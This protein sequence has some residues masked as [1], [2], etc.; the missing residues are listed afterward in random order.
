MMEEL[1]KKELQA[2]YRPQHTIDKKTAQNIRRYVARVQFHDWWIFNNT[3]P[4][5]TTLNGEWYKNGI[6]FEWDGNGKLTRAE[7]KGV[8]DVISMTFALQLS[9]EQLARQEREQELAEQQRRDEA[10]KEELNRRDRVISHVDRIHGDIKLLFIRYSHKR[11]AIIDLENTSNTLSMLAS[12]KLNTMF[13]ND[14][15][16]RV[17]GQL[18]DAALVELKI[19]NTQLGTIPDDDR[20]LI[21]IINLIGADAIV[22]VNYEN[23]EAIKIRYISEANTKKATRR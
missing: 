14:N 19:E 9:A 23:P 20:A 6:Y 16:E 17:D 8:T 1:S 5:E 4:S 10:L 13:S 2:R 15:I 11:I 7:K 12:Q 22:V 21:D 3:R 18:I